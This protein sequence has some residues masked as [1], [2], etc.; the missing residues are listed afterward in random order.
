MEDACAEG[1][2][3]FVS[4]MIEPAMGKYKV[5][6]LEHTGYSKRLT[7]VKSYYEMSR[8]MIKPDVRGELFFDNGPIYTRIMDAPPVR[9]VSGCEVEESVFGNGCVVRGRVK[10]SVIF[11][12][13]TI[14]T[15]ADVENC[16]IM[17]DSH[18]GAGAHLRNVIIDKNVQVMDGARLVGSPDNV[19]V[20]RK[21]S[22]VE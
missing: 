2:Y 21:R 10:E 4:D 18:I 6:G 7:T 8:D 13:V 5:A 1:R 12:G 15:G 9:Y 11:R 3:N 14:E 22:I 17:Q 20:V 19:T 16:V